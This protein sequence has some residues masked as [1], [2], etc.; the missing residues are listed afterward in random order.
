LIELLAVIAIIAILAGM[1]L[2][3]LPP[4]PKPRPRASSGAGSNKQLLRPAWHR[5]AGD[6]NDACA[7]SFSHSR[8]LKPAT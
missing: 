7:S 6:A 1:L 2:P 8:Y 3:A 5:Y 4:K